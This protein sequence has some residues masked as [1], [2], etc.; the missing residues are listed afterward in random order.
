[1]STPSSSKG[2]QRGEVKGRIDRG[3]E[4]IVTGWI[5]DGGVDGRQEGGHN[6]GGCIIFIKLDSFGLYSPS[7][8][9]LC[10]RRSTLWYDIIH[11]LEV[12]PSL[13]CELLEAGILLE[14]VIQYH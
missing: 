6:Q 14:R 11:L 5:D 13:V 2:K 8:D 12:P 1:M 9:C 7:Y 4:A 3:K 10:T